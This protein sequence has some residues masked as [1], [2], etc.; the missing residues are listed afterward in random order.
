M[1]K[2][3]IL[4]TLKLA[5]ENSK[6]RNFAQSIDLIINLKGIDLK[7]P[8]QNINTFV[9]LPH[10][11]G[12]NTKIGAFVSDE[13]Q[14]KAKEVCDL[15]INKKDFSKYGN[16][17]KELK[18]IAKNVDFF[19]AQANLMTD[20][21]K[22]FG[23]TLGPIGK[24]PNPKAGAVIPP[25]AIDLKPLVEKLRRTTKIQT[26]N[27][28]AI[29]AIIG[30]ENIKDEEITENI[31]AVYNA[32]LHAVPN[33][34]HSIRNSILKLTMGKPF[35]VGQKPIIKEE[36]KEESKIAKEVEVKKKEEKTQKK[37]ESRGKR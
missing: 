23:K 19:I 12:K 1:N 28:Q 29:K 4:E 32:V 18:K 27:E 14:N 26:K 35:I 36:K 8:E 30:K 3:Q 11:V 33:E 31:L 24:M 20:I 37:K 22:F 21:A 16:N 25:N 13:L 15:V 6:K 7:K 10:H 5:R 34:T 17:L 2:S 9:V